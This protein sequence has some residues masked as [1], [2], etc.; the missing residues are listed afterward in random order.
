MGAEDANV[1]RRLADRHPAESMNEEHGRAWMLAVKRRE[2]T[3][4]K[5]ARHFLVRFV[6]QPGQRPSIL[7]FAHDPVKLDARA[8][9]PG[10]QRHRRHNDRVMGESDLNEHTPI[11][12]AERRERRGESCPPGAC[13]I[14]FSCLIQV[15]C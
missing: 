14:S 9:L 3:L 15:N 2:M 6:V 5:P 12:E 11:D 1:E 13:A 7:E 4:E 8:D 10:G